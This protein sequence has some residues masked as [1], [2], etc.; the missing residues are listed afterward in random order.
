MLSDQLPGQLLIGDYTH[1]C[2]MISRCINAL[3][4]HDNISSQTC[5]EGKNSH[6]QL[7]VMQ[8]V[9]KSLQ[10][11]SCVILLSD[12]HQGFQSHI[13]TT[14]CWFTL[15]EQLRKKEHSVQW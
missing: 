2:T 11:Q 12:W 8:G 6:Q 7:Q 3:Q 5:L 9:C 15:S 10:S 1:W 14:V 4:D 13:W